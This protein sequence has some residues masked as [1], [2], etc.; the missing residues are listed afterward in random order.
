MKK[1]LLIG[2]VGLLLFTG[3]GSKKGD[4]VCTG[5]MN[6]GGEKAKTTFYG[7]L[8]DDKI[9]RVDVDMSFDKEETAKAICSTL[10]LTKTYAGDLAKD[11]NVKC[12]GKTVSIENF[13]D[14]G[15]G[16]DRLI[17][18]SKEAFIKGMEAEGMSCK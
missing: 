2:I 14:E 6:E 18:T 3:C 9:T 1:Y 10:E 17:G 11:M 12:S 7:Y 16:E 13:P 8:K 15:E 4:I 5:E